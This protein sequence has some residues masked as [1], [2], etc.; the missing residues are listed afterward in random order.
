MASNSN[1]LIICLG[2][3]KFVHQGRRKEIFPGELVLK[4]TFQKGDPADTTPP[5]LFLRR[6]CA[7]MHIKTGNGKVKTKEIVMRTDVD[8]DNEE[9]FL[10]GS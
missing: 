2:L 3:I 9:I 6:R 5:P 4:G 10:P 1:T 7:C 8:G